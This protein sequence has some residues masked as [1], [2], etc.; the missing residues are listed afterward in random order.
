MANAGLGTDEINVLIDEDK[1]AIVPVIDRSVRHIM[2]MLGTEFGR[3]C[4]DPDLWVNLMQ[5][6]LL[7]NIAPYIV[8]DDIRFENEAA[9]IRNL[10][11]LIIH[12]ERAELGAKTNDHAS[13]MG[14]MNH[15]RDIFVGNDDSIGDF[16]M[17]IE[18]IYSR[19][20]G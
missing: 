6:R 3:N 8:F 9:M 16:L 15:Y 2:Q 18:V 5:H 14:I 7:G 10:G 19:F 13:E 1:E 11:G 17:K 4:I 12:V 20:V